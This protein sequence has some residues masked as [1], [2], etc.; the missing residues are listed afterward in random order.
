MPSNCTLPLRINVMGLPSRM[1]AASAA[2][3]LSLPSPSPA[4][5]PSTPGGSHR[6]ALRAM[7]QL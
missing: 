7:P 1:L 4:A 3:L 5:P 2:A 6:D